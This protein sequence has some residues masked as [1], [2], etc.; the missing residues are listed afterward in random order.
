MVLFPVTLSDPLPRFQGHGDAL[1]ELCAQLTRDRFAI[2]KFLFEMEDTYGHF[3][4]L[5]YKQVVSIIR[6]ET[7]CGPP[8]LLLTVL[9]CLQFYLYTKFHSNW[10]NFL[11]T[12]GRTYGRTDIFPLY[13]IRSKS[14][15]LIKGVQKINLNR[16]A[17]AFTVCRFGKTLSV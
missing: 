2:A 12:D 5:C 4:P 9:Q 7:I 3:T 17:D 11:W 13:I 6:I 16:T 14:T 1:D 10:R 8:Q 15:Y